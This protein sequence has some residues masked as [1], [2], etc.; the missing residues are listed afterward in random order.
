MN[1]R[2]NLG[3]T[4]LHMAALY[5]QLAVAKLLIERGANVDARTN[6]GDTPLKYAT[7]RNNPDIAALL[8]EHGAKR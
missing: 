1:L 4:P 6:A 7:A 3:R 2:D 5:D 8:R